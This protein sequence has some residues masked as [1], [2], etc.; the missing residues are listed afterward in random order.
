M[1]YTQKKVKLTGTNMPLY[2]VANCEDSKIEVVLTADNKLCSITNRRNDKKHGFE[3]S[4]FDNG[5]L[6]DRYFYKNGIAEGM[7][8]ENYMNGIIRSEILNK[9]GEHNGKARHYY[10]NG[11]L[12]CERFLVNNKEDGKILTYRE[13]GNF[14]I[15]C[16]ND[17]H[18]KRNGLCRNFFRTGIIS[19]QAFYSDNRTTVANTEYYSNCGSKL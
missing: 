18:G 14:L 16:E 1:K 17:R 4:Y 12:Q 3:C 2:S 8:I 9:G 6:N 13:E 10:R 19:Y 7:T 15:V 11:Y 5:L